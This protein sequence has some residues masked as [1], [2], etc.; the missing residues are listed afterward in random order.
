MNARLTPPPSRSDDPDV[1]LSVFLY[2]TRL[3]YAARRSAAHLFLV[4]WNTRQACLAITLPDPPANLP[5]LPC[6]RLYL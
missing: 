4:E 5:R 3:D 2:D 1:H 6:E